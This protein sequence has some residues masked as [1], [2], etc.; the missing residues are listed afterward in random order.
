MKKQEI[1][2]FK[3]IRGYED[4]VVLP[5]RANIGDA[6][7]DFFA[8]EDII[9]HPMTIIGYRVS[10]GEPYHETEEVTKVPTGVKAYMQ[11]NEYLSLS[12][13][14]SLGK[15][16]LIIPN[17]PGIVDSGYFEN[18]DNDGHIQIMLLNISDTKIT[19]KKGEAVMQGVFLTYLTVDDDNVSTKRQGGI[20]STNK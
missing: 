15:R 4:K 16:G 17:S 7:Y 13:R 1:R 14:S 10:D 9:I 6:G 20:G 11:E 19:I 2:G 18:P 3:H 8:V 12:I 5:F